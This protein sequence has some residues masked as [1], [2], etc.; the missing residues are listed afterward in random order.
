MD[1]VRILVVDDEPDVRLSLAKVLRLG[2]PAPLH[3]ILLAGDGAEALA[4]LDTA[5]PAVLLSDLRM[6]GLS[7]TELLAETRRR[8]PHVARILMTGYHEVDGDPHLA[9]A[10]PALVFH[11]PWDRHALVA[12]LR[13]L[14]KP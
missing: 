11:K 9:A 14:L 5:R 6:P 13:A 2:F 3:E 7:G 8:A 10:A 12:A 4:L 1:P